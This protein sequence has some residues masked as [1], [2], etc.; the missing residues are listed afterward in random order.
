VGRGI[1]TLHTT[2]ILVL[3]TPYTLLFSPRGHDL[4]SQTWLPNVQHCVHSTPRPI[5]LSSHTLIPR[6]F[7]SARSAMARRQLYC[8]SRKSKPSLKQRPCNNCFQVCYTPLFPYNIFSWI[9]S[10][11]VPSIYT[12][13]RFSRLYHKN[14][15]SFIILDPSHLVT[16]LF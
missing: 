12:L 9:F 13:V 5:Q 1:I 2:L 16:F 3:L 6:R 10:L 4:R 15:N 11:H 7:A 14:S 8:L